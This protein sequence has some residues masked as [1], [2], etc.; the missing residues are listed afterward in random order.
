MINETTT[1]IL[2]SFW[3]LYFVSLKCYIKVFD[4]FFL[5]YLMLSCL[6]EIA[7]GVAVP[8]DT[9]WF[10]ALAA[11]CSR[12]KASDVAAL[13]TSATSSPWLIPDRS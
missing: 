1:T 3:P 4:Q 2:L 5:K 11:S 9:S 12:S 7:A 8:R 6:T 10:S 13:A